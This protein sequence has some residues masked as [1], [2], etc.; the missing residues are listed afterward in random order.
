MDNSRRVY[1]EQDRDH[2]IWSIVELFYRSYITFREQF[3]RY[4][5]CVFQHSYQ[6][7]MDRMELRLNP[8]DLAGLLDFK[9]LERLRDD[10]IH[11]L[12]DLCHLVFRG[13][14]RTDALDRYVSDIFHEISI[15][16]EEHYNVKTYA[17][18][19][20]RDAQETEL[21]YIL[22]EAHAMFPK[23]LNH[24]RFL[25]RRAQTRMEELL[26]TFTGNRIFKRSLYLNRDDFVKQAYDNG[27]RDFY[28]FLYPELGSLEGFYEA[29]MSFHESGFYRRALEAFRYA[30]KELVRDPGASP[31]NAATVERF[32]R[33]VRER[34]DELLKDE[35]KAGGKASALADREAGL[36]G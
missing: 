9:A 25:F 17:P 23:K 19:Y 33:K 6:K 3:E 10:Y 36:P 26:P 16:K 1:V 21:T 28:S 14:H 4:E 32:G 13:K 27:L 11:R 12:K 18:Q 7:G 34:I 31:Q 22:D 5:W 30:E 20:A 29:G 15:L 35:Q 8:D 24:I 2:T